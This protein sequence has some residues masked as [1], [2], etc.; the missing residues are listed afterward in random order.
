M[1]DVVGMVPA[2]ARAL[3]ARAS[4]ALVQA[5]PVPAAPEGVPATRDGAGQEEPGLAPEVA[6]SPRADPAA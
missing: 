6:E 4:A 3:A 1:R 2:A 5:A